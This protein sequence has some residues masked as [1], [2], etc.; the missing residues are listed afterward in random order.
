VTEYRITS[1]REIPT[2]VTARDPDGV[3]ANVELRL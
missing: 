2:M 3:T 1:W